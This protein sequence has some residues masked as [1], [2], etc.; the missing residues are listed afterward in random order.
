MESWYMNGPRVSDGNKLSSSCYV[1]E[2]SESDPWLLWTIDTSNGCQTVQLNNGTHLI[3]KNALQNT[4]DYGSNSII[5]RAVGQ[6][7]NF[8]CS[9][10]LD[11]PNRI[12]L[13]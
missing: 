8:K 12:S 6:I 10:Q 9:Y 11:D 13:R 2:Y 4:I 3:Y 1:K 5:S 7:I